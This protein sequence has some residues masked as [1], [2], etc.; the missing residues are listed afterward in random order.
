MAW[1]WFSAQLTYFKENTQ[2]SIYNRNYNRAYGITYVT[3]SAVK[4]VCANTNLLTYLLTSCA[5]WNISHCN[6]IIMNKT[7]QQASFVPITI[8]ITLFIISN[9]NGNENI[10]NVPPRV[11]WHCVQCVMF[12]MEEKK[13]DFKIFIYSNLDKIW[14]TQVQY[15]IVGFNITL[16][17]L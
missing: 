5:E 1:F 14:H 9:G 15:S 11:D 3:V 16:D 17:M 12:T 10:S 8:Y 13:L 2:C 7:N 6:I 4:F